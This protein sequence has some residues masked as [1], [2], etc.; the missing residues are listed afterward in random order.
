M[1]RYLVECDIAEARAGRGPLARKFQ[2]PITDAV[3]GFEISGIVEDM[4]GIDERLPDQATP[5]D[6]W[7]S[8]GNPSGSSRETRRLEATK[9][10][11]CHVPHPFGRGVRLDSKQGSNVKRRTKHGSCKCPFEGPRTESQVPQK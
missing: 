7:F 5:D 9:I 2:D 11:P 8:L 10:A 6:G 3:C 1:D 4:E